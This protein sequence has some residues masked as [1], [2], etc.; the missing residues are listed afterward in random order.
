ME[1]DVD[2]FKYIKPIFL[3]THSPPND[4]NQHVEA[5]MIQFLFLDSTHISDY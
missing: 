5:N 1:Y 3:F 4:I 2:M